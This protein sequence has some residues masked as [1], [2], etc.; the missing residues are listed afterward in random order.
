M[1]IKN[2]SKNVTNVRKQRRTTIKTSG[3]GKKYILCITGAFSK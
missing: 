2:I 3:S 1:D